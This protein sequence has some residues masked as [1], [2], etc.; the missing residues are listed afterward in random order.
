MLKYIHA[1]TVLFDCWYEIIAEFEQYTQKLL[2]FLPWVKDKY[3]N[4]LKKFFVFDI[5][6]I[7]LG[8]ILQL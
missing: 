1:E 5:H 3:Y 8:I 6:Y 4:S 2:F 7:Q